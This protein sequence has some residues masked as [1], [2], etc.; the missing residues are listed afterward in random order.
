MDSTKHLHN[1]ASLFHIDSHVNSPHTQITGF[2]YSRVQNPDTALGRPT[3]I[4]NR[5]IEFLI[6]CQEP[7]SLVMCAG[8]PP[9]A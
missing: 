5:I 8:P 6:V 2:F 9:C 3:E 1:F 4:G 7:H